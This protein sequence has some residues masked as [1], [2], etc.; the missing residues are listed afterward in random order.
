[1]NDDR[2]NVTDLTAPFDISC[3]MKILMLP[4]RDGVKLHTTIYFPPGLPERAPAVLLRSPYTRTTW[5]DP[6]Y[7]S[8]FA[9][10][11]VYILQACRGTGWSEGGVFH[12][13]DVDVEKNDAEDLF[14]WLKN[15]TWFN[16]R[17]AMFGA[18]YPG[19]TQW[20]AARCEN[21]PLV[22]VSPRVAPLHSCCG[23]VQKG[24]GAL[25]GF[26][27]NWP[28]SMY[29]R[30]TYGYAGVPDYDAMQVCRH[31]PVNECDRFAGYGKP[32]PIFQDF[33]QSAMTPPGEF[34]RRHET[35][36][37]GMRTPAFIQGGWFDG[38][39]R[40]SIESFQRM[41]H[42]SATEKSRNFTRL[43]VGPW[44]HAGLLNPEL[45]GKENN[46]EPMQARLEKFIFGLLKD[47][48][49]DPLAGEAAVRY[50]MLGENRWYDSADW[51]PPDAA[52]ETFY[53]HSGGNANTRRGDGALSR[54]A[55]GTE[56][57]DRC[58]SDPNT[59]VSPT[60]GNN[61]RGCCDRGKMEDRNDVLV[62]TTE[63]F[64]E[65]LT[66][67]GNVRLRF[68]A[69][70]ST[71]DTDFFATLTDVTPDGRSMLLTTGMIRAR[72]RNSLDKEELL[73]PGA[74]CAYE[75]DLGDVAV[76]FLPGHAMRLE[77]CGQ[78]FPAWD[79]NANTGNTP[80]TDTALR[81]S[82]HT[83]YHDADRPAELIL[84]VCPEP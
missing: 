13:S 45:F 20:C 16:G 52:P 83:V 31:L 58:V 29:H 43:T 5:F 11:C 57:P 35:W 74:V 48:D 67:T 55:P 1:M 63:K 69:A 49:R 39:K 66:V 84:P 23:A 17:C 65:P 56:L 64:A 40:E 24:G 30:R 81:T 47:P 36:F 70:A 15:Q 41:K 54:K 53:L 71:P 4:M 2:Y 44:G 38:F 8:A 77:I 37:A 72:Y 76:K 78:E 82:I 33:L 19:W 28:L 10:G 34:L 80:F 73:T 61:E 25:L 51:P 22:A 60:D 42:G 26:P 75:I 50:F 27:I 59:P 32:L 79:R 3:D 46:L 18:S 12:P 7:A 6:P 9:H 14:R 21:N 68:Y 62:Y